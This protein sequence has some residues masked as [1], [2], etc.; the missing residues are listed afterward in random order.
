MRTITGLFDNYDEAQ[1]VVGELEA[2]GVPSSDISLIANNRQCRI[3]WTGHA[4]NAVLFLTF[5]WGTLH[6]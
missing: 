1:D 3:C 2:T 4:A 5:L 6:P